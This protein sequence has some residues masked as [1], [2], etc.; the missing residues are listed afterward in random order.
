[1]KHTLFASTALAACAMLATPAMAQD[2][3]DGVEPEADDDI[4]I[5]TATRRAEDVQDIPLAVTAVS[6]EQ[7]DRQ[8]V[9]NVQDITSVSPS[10]S[11]SN[12]QLASGS[13]VLRIRGVGTTS[14]NIGFESAVGIFIDGAYQSRP[15]VALSEF[16]DVERVEVLR[17]PQGTLFGRNTSAGA[18]NITNRRPDLSEF[19]GFANA[20][21]G[22]RNLISVQGAV[23]LPVVQDTVAVRLTGAYRERD[24]YYTLLNGAGTNVGE[25]NAAD[26]F[27]LRGQVGWET[28][29]GF[30]GR[31]IADYAESNAPFGAALEVLQ[32][33]IEG[34]GLF[35]AVGL[36]ARGGMSGPAVATTPFDR[37][38]A[39]AAVDSRTAS[40]NF[41][42]ITQVENWGI[43]GEFE[44]PISDSAD[45]I[46]IGSYREFSS[47]EAYDS[48]FSGLDVFNVTGN[49]TSIETMTH[50]LRI[51]GDAWGGR[52]SWLIG[53]YYSDESITQS[54]SFQLG[55]DYGELI[56]ALFAGATGGASLFPPPAGLGLGANPLTLF[57]GGIDP[58]GTTNTN[59]YS[60]DSKSWS[61]FTH[62][63]LD[64][65][66]SLDLTVGLRYSDESKDGAF[67]Q[68]NNNN[69]LCPAVLGAIGAGG[70]PVPF[71]N[72][73][74][75]TGCF[76]FT[77]PADL[78]A[79][80]VFPLPR[81][82]AGEFSD[83]ELI[84]T[85]KLGYEF[86]APIN[87]YASYT[88]G[89]KSG[90]FNLDSTAAAGGADPRFLSEEVD[91]YEI[92]L[93]AKLLDNA[94]VLNVAAF[95]EEFSNFQVL[96]FTGAQFTTFNVPKANT[97]GLEIESTI[98]PNDNFT[99]NLGITYTDAAYPNDCAGTQTAP[100]VLA[101][102]G[103]SLTNAP[104]IV[105]IAGGLYEKEISNSLKFTLNGQVRFES[106][107]RTSTQAVDPSNLA[108]RIPVPFDEQDGNIKVNMRA[109]IGEIDGAWT[110][111]AFVNNLTNEITR[112]VTF[113]TVLRSGSRS[114]FI[115]EPRSYG[116]TVRTKF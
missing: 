38:S 25:S 108:A 31:I 30:S 15:G 8:G 102:C 79:A 3:A 76:A 23:N 7:L 46:Y 28:D 88:H 90:G 67:A 44:F 2:A 26:Q 71:I 39:Q 17:G 63:T 87:V 74:F 47:F 64:I 111:E 93:K 109:G 58:A 27:L 49:D 73:V 13:V 94:V 62:N 41:E 45:I 81:T 14:N 32:S 43:T 20:T 83:S 21:Y 11:T 51:Q 54:A 37:T 55:A 103:N 113:N 36:G 10:F 92:G 78:P 59:L 34:A 42:P 52:L 68:G 61:V 106:D 50:E 65:T 89:Y 116:V 80:A 100:N 22:N 5:V 82:F 115:Q 104:E 48:D 57:S 107:R 85:V 75:G 97:Q 29:S 18:L 114:A 91:A 53:G 19:G 77:A 84:Y 33:G 110:V 105:G 66:D 101:L 35:G 112:G 6:P 70:V 60:Q 24:G 72:T 99:F 40:V 4:I 86:A 98:R 69:T 96:E 12:A 56:G 1:M 95:R 16:V 9:V